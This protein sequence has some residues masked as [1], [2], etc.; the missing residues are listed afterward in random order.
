MRRKGERK[1]E[2]YRMKMLIQNARLISKADDLDRVANLVIEDGRIASI[3]EAPGQV[4][5]V[6]EGQG[7]CLA[8]GLVDLFAR[9]AEP[10]PEGEED[11]LSV[12]RAAAVGGY[13]TLCL[14]TGLQ[15]T[16]QAEYLR[17]RARYACCDIIPAALALD[18]KNLLNY[19]ALKLS[20]VGAIYEEEG[21]D[22]PLRMR[23]AMF[24]ARK[25]GL[26]LMARCRDR[27]LYGEGIMREGTQAGLL[28]MPIIP[29]SAEATVVA[30]DIILAQE[31]GSHIHLG[32]I[33]TALSVEMI[34]TAKARGAKVSC[35]TEPHYLALCSKEL[36]GYN[37]LAKLDPPLGN[38]EDAAA[39]VEGLR[40]GTI[41]CIAS[42]H[43][44]VRAFHKAKSMVT[45]ACGAASLETVL[46][47]SLTY[48]YHTGVMTLPELV[49]VLSTRPA[50]LLGLQ[51]GRL[52]P[53]LEADL[54]L[55]DPKTE[56][57]CRGEN[58]VSAGKNTPF[59]GKTLR[60]K[61]VYTI[62]SGQP[63]VNNGILQ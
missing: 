19:G 9:A 50:Q 33:S 11:I 60:G 47:V 38:P 22:H 49:H 31:S 27:R 54:V 1:L 16:G 42:G 59:E 46:A 62:K 28:E 57:V 63:V 43:T 8:P 30:R 24:R 39:L 14:H 4:D 6:I 12:S 5:Q 2:V 10:V 13:T 55:F 17:E 15:E 40:D 48:L 21:I 34:R 52:Q 23:D 41:D 45:A 53:G 20:G 29:A 37:T 26:L 61:V 7:L 35:S 32:H 51:T 56:W 58:F 3:G 18:G 44:P 36:R 25:Y